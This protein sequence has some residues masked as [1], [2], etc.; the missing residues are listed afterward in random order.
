MRAIHK[1]QVH[2]PRVGR[3]VKGGRVVLQKDDARFQVRRNLPALIPLLGQPAFHRIVN[4]QRTARIILRQIERVNRSAVFQVQ[5][6][7]RGGNAQIGAELKD[8]RRPRAPRQQR[9]AQP[10]DRRDG[11]RNAREERHGDA[12]VI[13][14]CGRQLRQA[15]FGQDGQV[16]VRPDG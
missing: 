2:L 4:G 16:D 15:H 13:G 7:L 5:R 8:L 3:L 10:L 6:Q 1:H 9:E 11:R 12:R 14:A